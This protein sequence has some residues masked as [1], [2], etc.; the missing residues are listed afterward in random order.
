MNNKLI[1]D[2]IKSSTTEFLPF[3]L[4]NWLWL[5]N[6][7]SKKWVVSV[8]DSGYTF[9]NY[10]FFSNLF[11]YVS[12]NCILHRKFIKEWTQ[13]RLKVSIGKH[14]YPDYYPGDYDW[15]KDFDVQ[16]VLDKGEPVVFI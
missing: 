3:R 15:T 7:E 8:S 2:I 11:K 16:E 10:E 6:P 14:C 13:E 4:G 12:L 1:L 5:I 9:Y